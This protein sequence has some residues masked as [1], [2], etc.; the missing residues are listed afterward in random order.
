MIYINK[1]SIVAISRNVDIPGSR[2][3]KKSFDGQNNLK[4]NFL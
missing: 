1:I 4:L 3:E 2:C